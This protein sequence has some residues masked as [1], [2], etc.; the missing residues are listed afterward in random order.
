M[1]FWKKHRLPMH[2]RQRF[3]K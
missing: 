3:I 1:R 2:R